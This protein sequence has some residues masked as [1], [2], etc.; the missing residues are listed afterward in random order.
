MKEPYM[1]S[2]PTL[3]QMLTSMAGAKAK[4]LGNITPNIDKA[5]HIIIKRRGKITVSR[6]GSPNRKIWVTVVPLK[7][8]TAKLVTR[9]K[10]RV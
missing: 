6:I 10:N 4:A 8:L 3:I 7:V 9:L 1:N 5:W 2:P